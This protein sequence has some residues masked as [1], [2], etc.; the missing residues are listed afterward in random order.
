M[1]FRFGKQSGL[2]GRI[3]RQEIARFSYVPKNEDKRPEYIFAYH[4]RIPSSTDEPD[5]FRDSITVRRD[6]DN[7][8]ELN[9]QG[10]EDVVLLLTIDADDTFRK[11]HPDIVSQNE[12][13]AIEG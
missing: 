7:E 9:Y 2:S 11:E 4:G 3:I 5:L 13:F 12:L 6:G 1:R 10:I 8:V